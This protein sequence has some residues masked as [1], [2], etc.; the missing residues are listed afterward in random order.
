MSEMRA[1]RCLATPCAPGWAMRRCGRLPPEAVPPH[2]LHSV[3]VLGTTCGQRSVRPVR[4]V[5]AVGSRR[6]VRG[7]CLLRGQG[8]SPLY[9]IAMP[10]APSRAKCTATARPMPAFACS[11]WE[12]AW[13]VQGERAPT[14]RP[15]P[16]AAHR[17][18]RVAAGDERHLALE[19][20][21]ALRGS[22]TKRGAR[23]V[24]HRWR[25]ERSLHRR[26][27]ERATPRAL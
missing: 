22:R 15:A 10:S 27:R 7:A 13:C 20:L 16:K 11:A 19:L 6:G 12:Q 18:T 5:R 1:P 14:R 3:G 25:V 21:G 17:R 8:A 24:A 2:R 26:P 4:S 9:T 23:G